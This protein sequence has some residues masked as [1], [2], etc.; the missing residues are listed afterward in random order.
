M[1]EVKDDNNLKEISIDDAK[2]EPFPARGGFATIH[3]GN[4]AGFGN[5]VVKK[6]TGEAKEHDFQRELEAAVKASSC[7]LLTHESK[8]CA[9]DYFVKPLAKCTAGLQIVYPFMAPGDLAKN[10]CIDQ[11]HTPVDTTDS[12]GNTALMLAAS[13]GKLPALRFLI[14]RKANVHHRNKYGDFALWWGVYE[15][16]K[17]I[18]EAL[19]NAGADKNM[20]TTAGQT[21]LDRA[22]T[23]GHAALAA[24]LR[25]WPADA[26][27]PTTAT[28]TAAAPTTE[29]TTAS[30]AAP[31]SVSLVVLFLFSARAD[32]VFCRPLSSKQRCAPRSLRNTKQNR[33]IW[34]P[35]RKRWRKKKRNV[36]VCCRVVHQ[37]M[38]QLRRR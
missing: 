11:Q 24:F 21:A 28:A 23:R 8:L 34:T 9:E 20:K 32:R 15:D 19:L 4:L 36:P 3:T 12:D 14:A 10:Q 29:A 31:L 38:L 7:K 18:T 26:R 37:R 6:F 1:A 2:L 16:R 13:H 22:T 17:D 25:S 5:V 35:S 27:A 30:A 33:P